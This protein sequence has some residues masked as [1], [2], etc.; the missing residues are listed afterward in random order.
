[1]GE[2]ARNLSL[3]LLG[4]GVP[5]GLFIIAARMLGKVAS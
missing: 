4:T 2:L 3:A 1:M 5:C